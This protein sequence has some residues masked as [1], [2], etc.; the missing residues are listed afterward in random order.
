MK[1]KTFPW[2]LPP[3][4]EGRLGENT[5]GPQRAIFEAGHLLLILHQPPGE[6]DLQR[7][8]ILF[9][10]KPN[11][12][13]WCNGRDGGEVKLR[14]LLQSYRSAWEECETEYEEAKTAK[15][16][17]SVLE[18]LVPLNRASTNL[19]IAVQKAREHVRKDRFLIAMRDEGH[20]VSRAFEL[21][22]ADAKLALDYR[23]AKNAEIHSA[24]AEEM[25][26]SQHKLNTLAA[27]T[28]PLMALATLFGMNLPSG[29]EE[30]PSLVFWVVV[31]SAFCVGFLVK[32]WV[33]GGGSDGED[34]ES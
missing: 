2:E 5:Y 3:E 18:K 15:D 13:H 1:R 26:I 16:L 14:Q 4:I 30:V 24:R 9:W 22:T 25:A 29:L 8:V 33:A 28:F 32:G 17:F 20:E 19:A 21:L 34:A 7:D 6:E 12:E 10:R 27:L 31:A 11:G 23:A